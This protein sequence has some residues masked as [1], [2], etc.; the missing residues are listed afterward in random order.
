MT[1]Y[2]SLCLVGLFHPIS[3]CGFFCPESAPASHEQAVFHR[4]DLITSSCVSQATHLIQLKAVL[5]PNIPAMPWCFHLSPNTN[6]QWDKPNNAFPSIAT[7]Q[8]RALLLTKPQ[9]LYLAEARYTRHWKLLLTPTLCGKPPLMR[10]SRSFWFPTNS[11]QQ[12]LSRSSSAPLGSGV[13]GLQ[14]LSV[15]LADSARVGTTD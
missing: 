8:G 13:T 5:P 1:V 11:R 4:F 6:T 12:S 7:P 15:L 3:T 2:S 10:M 14:N 9:L